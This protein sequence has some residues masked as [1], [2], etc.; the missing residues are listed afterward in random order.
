M[1]NMHRIRSR[2]INLLDSGPSL[3]LA[4]RYVSEILRSIDVDRIKAI[5]EKYS[6]DQYFSDGRKYLKFSW[7]IRDNIAR[8]INL[9][10]HKAKPC[11]I[12]DIGSGPGYFLLVCRYFGHS[13]QGLDL[14]DNPLYRELFAEFGIDRI[15]SAVRPFEPLV[16]LGGSYNLIT[17]YA[18][19]FCENIVEKNNKKWGNNEWEFFLSDIA[20]KLHKGGRIFLRM[21]VSDPIGIK[22][23]IMYPFFY[24]SSDKFIIDIMNRREALIR[25][26]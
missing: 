14:P 7:Y 3:F 13:V 26:R 5:I 16:G 20:P 1:D 6:N 8:A 4:E 21:N 15:E 18:A 19:T 2:F 17:A 25:L 23:R 11:R 22:S 10:L 9:G 24:E 12:L